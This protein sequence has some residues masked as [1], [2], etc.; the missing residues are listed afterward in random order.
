[1]DFRSVTVADLAGQVQ[2]GDVSAHELAEAALERIEALNPALNAFVALDPDAALAEADSIDARRAR[3]DDV[4]PLA[5]I[6]IGVKD[7]EDAAGF[8]TT[9]GCAVHADDEPATNDSVLVARLRQ[10]GC[11]VLG[12][13][14]TPE[15]GFKADTSNPLFGTTRNPWN[16]ERSA[17]GSSGGSA[18]ALASG[19]VPLC[20]GSDGGGSIRIPAAACGLTGFKPSLGRIPAGDVEAP[21]WGDLS[22]RGVMTRRIRDA[23][24]V[25][26]SVLGPDPRDL[27]SLPMPEQSWVDGISDVHLPRR[28]AWS[29]TLGYA[30]VDSEVLAL[31]EAAV[32]KIAAAG[33]EVVEIETV[34]DADPAWQ[35]ATLATMGTARRV[36]KWRGTPEWDKLDPDQVA[37]IDLMVERVQPLDIL[38]AQDKAH[39]LNQRLVK[40]FHGTSFLLTPTTAGQPGA[41]GS[42]GVIDGQEDIGW[43]TFTFPF[44]LTRSPAGTVPVG[45]S[46]AGVPVGLQ[47][48]GPQ[49]AD[50]AVLLLLAALED[51]IG[52]AGLAPVG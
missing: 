35:W 46:S 47:V 23:T 1:M 17:G 37:M 40:L 5:G 28:V 19:M 11:V 43:V 4:G 34:F 7:L 41:A 9:N 33:T 32:E 42:Q 18:A 45:L 24:L 26:D 51:L 12:K 2:A 50:M 52:F 25:L 3:G 48:V 27:R 20:T 8:V 15:F 30:R 29:P 6:P 14:N 31:C 22:T 10:A 44:N 49:R 21:A 39:E 36:E 38:R 16:A 13:T